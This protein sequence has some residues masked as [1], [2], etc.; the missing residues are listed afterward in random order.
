MSP[1][2]I[3]LPP[4]LEG[5]IRRLDATLKR[6]LE[7][8]VQMSG[9]GWYERFKARQAEIRENQQQAERTRSEV[10]RIL[11]QLLDL[12]LEGSDDVR[13]LIRDLLAQCH[14][15]RWSLGPDMSHRPASNDEVRRLLALFSMKDQE[16]DWR[17]AI[18]WLGAV[19]SRAVAAGLDLAPALRAIA[20]LSSDTPRFKG[21]RSTRVMMLD[22]AA[23]VEGEAAPKA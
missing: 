11:P 12:Y 20:Q 1:D 5:E 17:D 3:G 23:R 21:H 7:S 22:Y 8:G 6:L 10:E 16:G 19:C 9:P 14:W 4:S 13:A 2:P 18:L 15:V